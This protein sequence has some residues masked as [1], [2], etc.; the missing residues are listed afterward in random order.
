MLK[1]RRKPTAL[2]MAGGRNRRRMK[3]CTQTELW[4]RSKRHHKSGFSLSHA[5]WDCPLYQRCSKEEENY[6]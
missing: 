3:S 2:R 4:L 1:C 6:L 5:G